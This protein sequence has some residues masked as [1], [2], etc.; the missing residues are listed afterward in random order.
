[1][2]INQPLPTDTLPLLLVED[3]ETDRMACHRALAPENITIVEATTG[4]QALEEIGKRAFSCILLDYS[5]PDM[6]GLEILSHI[7]TAPNGANADTP[8]AM[9]TGQGNEKVAVAALKSGA[10]DYIVKDTMGGYLSILATVVKRMILDG[11]VA[12]RYQQAEQEN[13][14]LQ[15]NH[16]QVLNAMREGILVI[17]TEGTITFANPAASHMT[18]IPMPRL[19]GQPVTAAISHTSQDG[20]PYT[21]STSPFAKAIRT[22]QTQHSDRESFT[23]EG[24]EPFPVEYTCP[25]LTGVGNQ[26]TG[27]VVVFQDITR[28]KM[29][30]RYI[31][32]LAFHDQ[33]TGLGN[34]MMFK[35]QANAALARAKRQNS[36]TA[37]V[38]I[39]L[40]H[41]KRI[42]DTIGHDAGDQLLCETA[43]RLRDVL[44]DGDATF[45]MGGDEFV[46][47]VEDIKDVHG[48]TQVVKK[49]IDAFGPPVQLSEHS[50]KAELSIGASVYPW[51]GETVQDLMRHADQAMYQSKKTAGTSFCLYEAALS[52]TPAEQSSIAQQ[53]DHVLENDELSLQFQPQYHLGTNRL[54][55]FE[56]LLRWNNPKLGAVRP[57][58]FI[59]ISEESQLIHTIGGWVL[60]QACRQHPGKRHRQRLCVNISSRQLQQP[61]FADLLQ[62]TLRQANITPS[63]LELE[64]REAALL[65][66]A[67][68]LRPTMQQISKLGVRFVVD[69]FGLG[70]SS[71]VQYLKNLPITKLKIDKTLIQGIPDVREDVVTIPA[72]IT[73]AHNLNIEVTAEGVETEEQLAFLREHGCDSAQGYFLGRPET[74][75]EIV[76]ETAPEILAS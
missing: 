42:N 21:W 50:L 9:L 63:Q 46:M 15:R 39:D 18:G 53:L 6:T 25:P 17:D 3:S 61:T 62:E 38:F 55:G 47:L 7:N 51:H 54:C 57:N 73:M 8:V 29:A 16:E 48:L 69:D 41:F 56:A 4:H 66:H 33:L 45:R 23:I 34:R 44:R 5:L 10:R 67:E 58:I 32:D 71:S 64:I 14:Q 72:I 12:R 70:Y 49:L 27:V 31:S 30:D 74:A 35:H 19:V 59:P 60:T 24:R 20:Q 52:E 28:R 40:D 65:D 13:L 1:M 76:A 22:S 11:Q 36:K 26:A 68:T 2:P 43:N 75:S 37:M